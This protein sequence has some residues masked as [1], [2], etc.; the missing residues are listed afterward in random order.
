MTVPFDVAALT[1]TTQLHLPMAPSLYGWRGEWG[2]NGSGL[3]V[4]EFDKHVAESASLL[5][6]Q[7]LSVDWCIFAAG[8][9]LW[10]YLFLVVL[11]PRPRCTCRE[12][13]DGKIVVITG[14]VIMFVVVK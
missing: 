7:P 4:D 2:A 13:L 9:A 10:A 8:L 1:A 3:P 11:A 12:R 14:M 6:G 5:H